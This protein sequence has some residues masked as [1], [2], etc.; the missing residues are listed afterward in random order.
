MCHLRKPMFPP[1]IPTSKS[2]HGFR[3]YWD[4]VTVQKYATTENGFDFLP[5]RKP[6]TALLEVVS[7]ARALFAT[8]D[9]MFNNPAIGIDIVRWVV[10]RRAIQN[11]A[12]SVQASGDCLFRMCRLAVQMFIAE[13]IEPMA[14]LCLYHQNSSRALLLAVDD[15]DRLDYWDM[16]PEVLVWA[17]VVGGYTA[18]ESSI[19]WWYAEQLR[20][21]P[22][23]LEKQCWMQV[24]ELSERFLP[25]R[26]RQGEGLRQFWEDACAWLSGPKLPR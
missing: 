24:Q 2:L 12:M 15:C 8:Y 21:S 6:V 3:G 1:L 5:H 4:A 25:F 10:T 26:Y 9:T 7:K 18:R 23:P 14:E 22:I 16:H 11:E 19:R 20:H 13:S 17:T